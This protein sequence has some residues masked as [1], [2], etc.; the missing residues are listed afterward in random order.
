M[1]ENE[2]CTRVFGT[3]IEIHTALG[4][5]L[6]ESS[7]RHCLGHKLKKLGLIIEEEKTMPLVFKEAILDC[8]YRIDL[9]VQKTCCRN[10]K[11]F[12]IQRHSF[13]TNSNLS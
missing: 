12:G 6:L 9:L 13:G 1:T 4:P 3:A 8:G 7:Y 5:G 10:Q 11:R 2:I